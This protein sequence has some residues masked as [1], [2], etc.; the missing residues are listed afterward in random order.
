MFH[1]IVPGGDI[2]KNLSVAHLHRE[3]GGVVRP[4]IEGAAGAEIEAGVMPMAGKDSI[5]DAAAVKGKAHMGAAVVERVDFAFVVDEDDDMAV[6]MD[7][8]QADFRNFCDSCN[9]LIGVQR[10]A[11]WSSWAS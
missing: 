1:R 11:L 5:L 7:G 3:S 9:T 10:R 4:Q 8:V 6:Q 2:H